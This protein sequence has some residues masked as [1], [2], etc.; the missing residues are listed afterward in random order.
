MVLN[1]ET[2][3]KPSKYISNLQQTTQVVINLWC[4]FKASSF[5]PPIGLIMFEHV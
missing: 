4:I 2:I 1:I 3:K 5:I